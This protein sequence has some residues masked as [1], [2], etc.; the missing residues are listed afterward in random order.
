MTG[1]AA[2]STVSTVST[3]PAAVS[4]GHHRLDVQGLRAVAVTA[5][6]LYHAGMPLAGGYL[7]VDIF[8]VVSGFVITGLLARERAATGQTRLGTFYARRFRRLVPALSLMVAVTL[9]VSA[10]VLSP[11]GPQQT[12]VATGIGAMVLA[13]N[14]VIAQ[15]TGDY[16]GVPAET[17]PLLHT[18]SLSVEEQ[19]YLVFPLLLLITWSVLARRGSSRA[20]GAG[21]WPAGA[22]TVVTISVLSLALTVAAALAPGGEP[23]ILGFYSPVTRAWEFGAGALVALW[24]HRGAPSR[25]LSRVA[26]P[27]GAV[28]V[29]ATLVVPSGATGAGTRQ[30][31]ATLLCVAGTALVV[32]AGG[33]ATSPVT[34]ALSARPVVAVGDRS[35]ALYLWHWPVIVLASLVLPGAG[36]VPVAAALASVPIA[37]ASYRWVEQPLR[38]RRPGGRPVLPVLVAATLVPPFAV[39]IVVT[40]VTGV[41]QEEPAVRALAAA[42]VSPAVVTG[43]CDTVT[44]RWCTWD[45]DAGGRP[46]YLVGDSHAGHFGDGVALAGAAEER[47]V[48]ATMAYSCPFTPGL[49]VS[50]DAA[51]RTCFERNEALLAD[52]LA[53]APGT[54]LIANADTYWTDPL[55]SVAAGAGPVTTRSADKLALLDRSLDDTV[56]RLAAAGHEVVLVQSVPLHE[57]FHPERCTLDAI[58]DSGCADQVSRKALT[59]LQGSQRTVLF[60][61]ARRTGS[62]VFDP[63]VS[64]CGPQS[65]VT[66]RD[67][68]PLYRNWSHI[69]V[70]AS[71]E[72]AP[73]LGAPLGGRA[74]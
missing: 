24:A 67:G 2:V 17:N 73:A 18:W 71:E 23:G 69:S 46:V 55:W 34:R 28:L 50:L 51:W 6:I 43:G 7:G 10:F 38:H 29:A 63:W 64:L 54:V 8:F 57:G 32:W 15:T 22:V 72:L 33:H 58:R 39:A 5:V 66:E 27:V 44:V 31:V 12:A 49:R 48:V 52:L 9:S 21:R 60:D 59:D 19:F 14:V 68:V 26:A 11:L 3:G 65:C 16:F 37:F 35:Y 41:R 45:A 53:D 62:Q 47:P 36:W 20:T 42:A 74:G 40:S 61:V 4:A 13:A 70:A 1:P 30:L 25:P 56:S